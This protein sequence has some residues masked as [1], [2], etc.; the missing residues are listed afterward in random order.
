M[1]VTD[2]SPRSRATEEELLQ[3]A[4]D[5]IPALKERAART[6]ELRRIPR[7]TIGDVVA[8]GLIRIGTPKRF[9]GLDV[10]YGLMLDV[11]VELGRGCGATAWCYALWAA[12][13]WL[14]GHW[15]LAA[16]EEVFAG[17]PDLLSSSAFAPAGARVEAVAGGFRLSGRWQFSSGCDAATWVM[18]GAP[19]ADGPMWV[20]VPRSDYQIVDTWFVSG[21]R[22]TGSKDIAI[23]GAFVP[24]HRVLPGPFTAGGVES[25]G[26]KLHRQARYCLPVG[27]LLGWDLVAPMVGIAQG[28]VDAFTDR[29]RC[30]AGPGKS[31]ESTVIQNR[32]AEATAE[33]DA[34]RA[35][36][37]QD[38]REMLARAARGE[39]FSPL[40]VARYRR[41]K[42]FVS[43][44][45]VQAVERLFEVSGAHA[46][47]ESDPLQRMHRDVVAAS[48]RDGQ[49]LDFGGQHYARLALGL[50]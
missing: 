30:T 3:R 32:L 34:A 17:G 24:S 14:I 20:L 39:Q 8:S 2:M 10:G 45:A 48:H 35:V 40:D 31:A 13:A 33:V 49:I 15:P 44:L 11:A 16:Q 43:K 50:T 28:A 38:V 29:F 18:L 1:V 19:G 47:F 27:C 12:H 46:L 26:W 5:L 41:D 9:G 36:M 23:E 4:S 25:I 6:E 42:A 22:G 21:L 7:E 37:R